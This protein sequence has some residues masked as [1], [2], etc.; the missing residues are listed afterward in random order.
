MNTP[1]S[2]LLITVISNSGSCYSYNAG[3]HIEETHEIEYFDEIKDSISYI[4]GLELSNLE[5]KKENNP[6]LEINILING[7]DI[8]DYTFD[9]EYKEYE[10]YVTSIYYEIKNK[11][12]VEILNAESSDKKKA[13]E[14]KEKDR[15][16]NEKNNKI[17][18]EKE[19]E[20][21]MKLY[22]S[23]KKEFEKK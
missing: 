1:K 11:V 4:A 21:K 18:K 6:L 16:E 8:E 19:K 20:D 5:R 23:L 13:E 15:I 7:A 12:A 10:E 2:P 3:I 14:K 22:L 9:I 17:K